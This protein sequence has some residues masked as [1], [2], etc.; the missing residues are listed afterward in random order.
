MLIEEASSSDEM[1]LRYRGERISSEGIDA[2]SISALP[3]SCELDLSHKADCPHTRVD[4]PNNGLVP[5]PHGSK[6]IKFNCYGND[7][8][9]C[10]PSC[11]TEVNA[12]AD[13]QDAKDTKE[14]ETAGSFS[15][16][17]EPIWRDVADRMREDL[18]RQFDGLLVT[19]LDTMIS[20][21]LA[22]RQVL[23]AEHEDHCYH[24][25]Y[26]CSINVY[27]GSFFPLVIRTFPSLLTLLAG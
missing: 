15:S 4:L 20:G 19:G 3:D 11:L 5:N 8:T 1:K 27:F 14:T 6:Y 24:A 17:H 26:A 22:S 18:L 23:L 21:V 2:S 25:R 13:N 16:L 7:G 12:C 9:D 10:Q